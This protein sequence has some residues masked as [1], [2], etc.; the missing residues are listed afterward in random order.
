MRTFNVAVTRAFTNAQMS[1]AG[2]NTY[3]K[4]AQGEIRALVVRYPN[5]I[6]DGSIVEVGDSGDADWQRMRISGSAQI[7]QSFSPSR[8]YAASTLYDW[9]TARTA[10]MRWDA[11]ANLASYNRHMDTWVNGS[12]WLD[13][14]N[15]GGWTPGNTATVVYVGS[16]MGGAHGLN[17]IIARLR[18]YGDYQPD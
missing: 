10:R 13:V 1:N 5:Q 9:T 4:A 2:G 11:D 16:N 14:Y 3:H 8:F 12:N 7:L 15:Y 6:Q 18:I 17:G